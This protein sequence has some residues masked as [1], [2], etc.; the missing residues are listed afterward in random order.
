MRIALRATWWLVGLGISAI[1]MS[2]MFARPAAPAEADV[3]AGAIKQ[4]CKTFHC[5]NEPLRQPVYPTRPLPPDARD[6]RVQIDE[7]GRERI[8]IFTTT[9]TPAEVFAF[10]RHALVEDGWSASEPE[11][12]W[13]G[14]TYLNTVAAPAFSLYVIILATPPD[15]TE[16]QISHAISG[17]FSSHGWPLY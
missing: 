9:L 12:N 11:Q 2:V 3:V 8:T 16:V 4:P 5:S 15:L 7:S 6:V 1:L 17:P 14:F 10:Y 13:M